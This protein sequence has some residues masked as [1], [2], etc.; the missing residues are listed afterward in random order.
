M[1]INFSRNKWHFF[2]RF[3]PKFRLFPDVWPSKQAGFSPYIICL[4][5]FDCHT[6]LLS[7]MGSL[8]FSSCLVRS[9]WSETLGQVFFK[10]S[11]KSP[12]S[13]KMDFSWK[14]ES[15]IMKNATRSNRYIL[16]SSNAQLIRSSYSDWGKNWWLWSRNID[17]QT[18]QA[19][20]KTPC[21]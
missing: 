14:T 20:K 2:S 12:F 15:T 17:D 13:L 19:I 21:I 8:V 3:Y 4:P 18:P 16:V 5:S 6:Y 11:L 9:Q 10:N 1:I 7:K